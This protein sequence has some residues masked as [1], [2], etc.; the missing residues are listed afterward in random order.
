MRSIG[1]LSLCALAGA[2]LSATAAAGQ[3]AAPTA[4]IVNNVNE[5]NLVTL[6]GNTVP[7]ATAKN[8]R[9]PVSADLPMNDLLLVLSRSPQ[10]Q[11]AFDSFVASQYDPKSEN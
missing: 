4:Q 6:R 10:Q 9:G 3:G 1:L 5:N 11:A 8:D 7:M 2:L